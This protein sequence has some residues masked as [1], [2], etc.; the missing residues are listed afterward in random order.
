MAV[1]IASQSTVLTLVINLTVWWVS[2][3]FNII[4]DILSLEAQLSRDSDAKLEVG[5]QTRTCREISLDLC[6]FTLV[7]LW[8]SRLCYG[9]PGVMVSQPASA[10]GDIALGDDPV[11]FPA[12]NKKP[13]KVDKQELDA[14]HQ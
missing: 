9:Y 13:L 4:W 1:T 5:T 7:G 6:N 14:G 12:K 8:S 3:V 2:I 10:P 11:Q